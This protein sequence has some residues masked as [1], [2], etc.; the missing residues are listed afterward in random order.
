MSQKDI[1]TLVQRYKQALDAGKTPYFD[2]DEFSDLADYFDSADDLDAASEVI[3][4]GLAIHPGSILLLVKK[5]KI[6][7]YDGQ[8]EEALDLLKSITEY[9]FDLFL[10]KV[11]CSLQ[12][13]YYKVALQLSEELL[14]KEDNEPL[15]NV[16][17]ELGFVYV[18]ADCFK[19]AVLYFDE[20]LKYNSENIDVLSDLSYAHEMLGDFDAAIQTTNKILDIEPYT[21]EAWINL[22]KLHSLKEDYEKA[23]DAF[24]FAFTINDSD[25]TVLKL[26]A[27]CMSLCGRQ[28]EAIEIFRT[29]LES[30]DDTSIYLLIA[31]CYQSLGLFDQAV[32]ALKEY[33]SQ[34]GETEEYLS[35]LAYVYMQKEDFVQAKQTVL[36]GLDLNPESFDLN[37]TAGEIEFKQGEYEEAELYYLSIYPQNKDSFQLLD[38]MALLNIKVENYQEAA[39][40]TEKLLEI[41]PNNLAVKERLALLYFEIDDKIEFNAILDQ[42]TDNELLDLFQLIYVPQSSDSFDREMLISYLNRAREAR[43]LFKNLKY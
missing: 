42:F 33:K 16:F 3:D 14:E 13:G 22:G 32:E 23:I 7:A 27:H 17:A 24:E 37:M 28:E 20:S 29:L 5:A 31:E 4:T 38:R 21:Y 39:Y 40:H 36:K 41:D 18:E 15:D 6:C 30:D 34:E 9:D 10:L 11:E 19:E 43:T 8:Y 35:K 1:T 2:A 26:K 25:D 12:L